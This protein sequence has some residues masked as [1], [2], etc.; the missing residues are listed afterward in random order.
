MA[1]AAALSLA[2]SPARAQLGTP[3]GAQAPDSA[4]PRAAVLSLGDAIREA[5]Q[6]AFGNRIATAT[7]SK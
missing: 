5:D 2:A 4:A 1:L 6:R 3:R 7:A